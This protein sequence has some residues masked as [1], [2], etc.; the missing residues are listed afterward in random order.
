MS[1]NKFIA[2]EN[3]FDESTLR[4][5]FYLSSQGYFENIDGPISTGKESN[6]FSVSYKNEKRVVKIY[7]TS[8][9]FKKMYEYMKADPRFS[10]LQGTKLSIIYTWAK[11]E[12]RNLLR[13]REKGVSSP[14][15]YAVHKN[16]LVMEYFDAPRLAQKAPKDPKKFYERLIS[17]VGKLFS[18]GL[19]HAD[20]SEYNI[21]NYKEKPILIDFSHGLDLLYPNVQELL[22]RDIQNLVRYFGKLGLHL[23]KKKEFERIW[24][25]KNL[26]SP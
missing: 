21:L 4:G 1:K 17:E 18:A 5:L 13:A 7:R 2:Y 25:H 6:V 14:T 12:Y 20:L 8:A 23:D 11:K 15:P 3:V 19:V 26:K 9:H 10:A 16:I 24:T 22:E